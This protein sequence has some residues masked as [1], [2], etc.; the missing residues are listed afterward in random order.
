MNDGRAEGD[1]QMDAQ[2]VLQLQ[3]IDTRLDQARHALDHLEE[4]RVHEQCRENLARVRSTRDDVRRDLDM[5]TSELTAIETESARLDAQ[6]TRLEAQL[7]TVISPREAEALQHELQT[8]ALQ[9]SD[10]DDRG[11][12]LLDAQS[13][14]Q[15][16]LDDLAVSE[17]QADSDE[18]AARASL[19]HAIRV[20]DTAI[21]SLVSERAVMADKVDNLTEY[22]TRR[23]SSGGVAIATLIK[24][25]CGGCHTVLSISELDSLKRLP[26]DVLAECPNCSRWLVR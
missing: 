22:E 15:S 20:A 5:M 7:K 1:E 4:R 21:A 19:D 17:R 9:R 8:L 26:V 14:A 23:R 10:L 16:D 13:R 12:E 6:R 25:V 3:D 24:G 2:I 11:L 18:V